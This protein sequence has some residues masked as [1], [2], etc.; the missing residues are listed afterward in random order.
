MA[1][2][3]SKLYITGTPGNALQVQLQGLGD[4]FTKLSIITLGNKHGFNPKATSRP[5]VDYVY[6]T[7]SSI[8]LQQIFFVKL[9]ASKRLVFRDT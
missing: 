9:T 7:G 8:I 3:L 5:P 6:R 1:A 2:I 4:R